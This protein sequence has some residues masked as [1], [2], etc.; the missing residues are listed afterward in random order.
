MRWGVTIF[1]MPP[2]TAATVNQFPNSKVSDVEREEER[3]EGQGGHLLFLIR[4]DQSSSPTL[5]LSQHLWYSC[6]FQALFLSLFPLYTSFWVPSKELNGTEEGCHFKMS[7]SRNKDPLT[8][9]FF[10]SIRSL[11]TWEYFGYFS[12][13]DLQSQAAALWGLTE[14][15]TLSTTSAVVHNNVSIIC[16]FTAAWN[17]DGIRE[18][19]SIIDD[20]HKV[21]KCNHLSLVLK[22]LW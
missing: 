5:S 1:K 18:E 15:V 12:T 17:S 10:R 6:P 2:S 22:R 16:L 8:P 14:V 20:G 4:M 21:G 3:E 9:V 7:P 19:S 13:F 11:H